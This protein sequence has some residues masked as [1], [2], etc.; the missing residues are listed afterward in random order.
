MS[1]YI[2][3]IIGISRYGTVILRWHSVSLF[4]RIY[5]GK[6]EGKKS[7]AGSFMEIGM[8]CIWLRKRPSL[9][10]VGTFPEVGFTTLRRDSLTSSVEHHGE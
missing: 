4:G 8:G 1:E 5:S 6:L 9:D 10:V 2:E 3:M 7:F